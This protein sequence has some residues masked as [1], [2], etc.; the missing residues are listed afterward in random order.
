MAKHF[1]AALFAIHPL[2]VE[3]VAWV[4]ERKDV[5]GTLFWMLTLWA[6][7]AYVE[8]P[9]GAHLRPGDGGV[10]A[11]VDGQA[12]V[13]DAASGPLAPGLLAALPLAPSRRPSAASR[14]AASWSRKFPL[15][16]LTVASCVVTVI[17]Q[18]HAIVPLE[19]FPFHSAIPN[20]LRAYGDYL[21]KMAWPVDLVVFYSQPRKFE[22]LLLQSVAAGILLTAIT[23]GVLVAPGAALFG[24]GLVLVFGNAGAPSSVSCRSGPSRWPTAT[25]MSP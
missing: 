21:V 6:Y 24:R 7:L 3:S 15:L 16:A 8:R 4:S 22:V 9:G 1:A 12:D 5:L 20:A 17:A 13:G 2:H 10:C 18:R 25:P 14:S 19:R 11:G 23:I